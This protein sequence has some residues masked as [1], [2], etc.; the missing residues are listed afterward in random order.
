ML[1]G[2]AYGSDGTSGEGRSVVGE[3]DSGSLG[4]G[5]EGSSLVAGGVVSFGVSG[6]LVSLSPF[7]FPGACEVVSG[8]VC[9]G[10]SRLSAVV[11]G[12]TVLLGVAV[13]SG[14]SAASLISGAELS[15][16]PF[17]P[18]PFG[19]DTNDREESIESELRLQPV[20]LTQ[21][22]M[23]MKSAVIRFI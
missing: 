8:F 12:T 14:L 19:S 4:A 3:D 5:V 10:V 1:N 23:Q 18:V 15:A 6:F 2:Y 20:K 16:V 21:S 11:S 17:V 7:V 22:R 13:L 9:I